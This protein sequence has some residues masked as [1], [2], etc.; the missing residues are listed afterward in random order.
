[1]L[2]KLKKVTKTSKDVIDFLNKQINKI[3]SSSCDKDIIT[4]VRHTNI[5][6]APKHNNDI[7][8]AHKEHKKTFNKVLIQIKLCNKALKQVN[9]TP[10]DPQKCKKEHKK[11]FNKV[12][13]QLIV[14]NSM[15]MQKHAYNIHKKALNKVHVELI[16]NNNMQMQKNTY[17][18]H[19]KAL[20]KVHMQ[21]IEN[22]KVSIENSA[23]YKDSSANIE[24]N[25]QTIVPTFNEI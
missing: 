13:I 23:G 22:T 6:K 11:L 17:N 3:L 4:N 7:N 21:L 19:K 8:N 9:N 2:S 10:Y 16:E 5:K 14:N 18:M 20:N 15:E 12:L 24:V 1:M 25:K